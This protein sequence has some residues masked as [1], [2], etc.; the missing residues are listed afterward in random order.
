MYDIDLMTRLVDLQLELKT[1][2]NEYDDL[3]FVDVEHRMVCHRS[4]Y[5]IGEMQRVRCDIAELV[6]RLAGEY[7]P[8]SGYNTADYQ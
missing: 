5:L 2:S 8:A 6:Q 7:I 3:D 1:L 4:H